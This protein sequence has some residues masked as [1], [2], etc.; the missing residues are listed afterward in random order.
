MKNRKTKL[1]LAL[2]I[3]IALI[4]YIQQF[5]NKGKNEITENAENPEI[6][7]LLP[8]KGSARITDKSLKYK[9]AIE[10]V[11]PDGYI[12]TDYLNISGNIGK[13]VI[14]LDF[15][16]YSCINCQRTLPY[17][18][19]WWEKYKDKGLL[20]IG[21][22]TP[23]FEFEKDYDNVK[24]AAEKFGIGYPIVQDNSFRTWRAYENRY[25][26]RKYIIDIDGFIVYDHIGEG[27]YAETEEVIQKLLREKEDVLGTQMKIPETLINIDA[28]RPQNLRTPE[29]YFGYGF[30]RSQLGNPEGLKPGNTVDYMLPESIE[31]NKFYL[32]GSWKN[33]NDDM[34]SM[35]DGKIVLGYFAKKVN[36]VAGSDEPVEITIYN[37]GEEIKK[38]TI[39]DFG[40]YDLV[41]L[42]S[43]GEHIL[44]IETEKGLRAF[45][46]TFG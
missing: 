24:R 15:W 43:P 1:V 19:S 9:R 33:N 26:P 36:I 13:K 23:E 45:T 22:H 8:D 40:L 28:D 34:E 6:K 21:V 35:G 31:K 7:N 44:R 32:E 25:W 27:A 16:T 17:L 11:S 46:F 39:K 5:S 18:N 38:L 20:I 37:D 10:L 4:F 3:I 30:S 2:V 41:S 29:I 14:L 12:N 42:D